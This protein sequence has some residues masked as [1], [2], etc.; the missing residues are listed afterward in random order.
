MLPLHWTLILIL[1]STLTAASPPPYRVL[2]VIADQWQD[3]A[4]TLI[5]GGHEFNVIAALLKTWG[6]PFDVLRLDQQILDDYHLLDREGGTRYGTIVWA[7]G[8]AGA[9]S[10]GLDRLTPLVNQ[11]GAN[12]IALGD[13]VVIPEI[14]ALT[15][16]EFSSDNRLSASLRIERD[17]F[18]TRELKGREQEL[19]RSGSATPGYKVTAHESTVLVSRGGPFL[20]I[21]EPAQGGRIVWLGAYRG[22]AQIARQLLRDLFKRSLVWAQGYALYAEYPRS[23]LIEMHDNGNSEK[24]MNP[25]W[26][27]HALSEEQFRSSVIEPLK[28]HRAVVTQV[29]NTGFVDRHTRR[30]LNPWLQTKAP[31]YIDPPVTHDYSSTKRGLDAGAKEGVFEINSHGWTHFLPDLESAPGPLWTAAPDG[32]GSL[33]WF[34]EFNDRLRK[35]DVPAAT[36]RFHML[37]SIEYLRRDFGV[38]PLF[39]R[40]P[41]GAFS[42]SPAHHTGRIAASVGFGLAR[43]SSP[44]YLGHDFVIQLGP[45]V[46]GNTWA[47][48]QP[49]PTDSDV[50]WTV[51]G[52][53]FLAFHDRDVAMDAGWFA[54]VLEGLGP[55][56]RFMTA[57]EYVAYLHARVGLDRRPGGS[58]AFSV[59]YDD[60]Y[61]SYFATHKSSW[62]L[63]L[64]D[65]TRR[66]LPA[67]R[68]EKRTVTLPA[69]LGTQEIPF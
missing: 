37:R 21:R 39:L 43:F 6:I 36:Q 5:E 29:V 40:P 56:V 2:L 20:A 41:G 10:K 4:S 58:P 52:P 27:L 53:F 9:N 62:T 12:L 45:V 34:N 57:N 8:P 17:H 55:G 13:S 26:H 68:P 23:V 69:K 14:A 1:A 54:R 48:T 33:E 3:P 67:S 50:P 24:T 19:V 44:Y 61:C 42:A 7:T 25:F 46:T 66:A 18:L 30:V 60:H 59:T 63:H 15:G 11:Q 32:V 64:S 47:F 28:R 31:D 38:R 51:D 22:S 65:E 35:R 16:I 49:N